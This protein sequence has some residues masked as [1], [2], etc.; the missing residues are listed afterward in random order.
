MIEAVVFDLDGVLLDSESAWA[1]VKRELTVETGGHWTD[2][3]STA[4]LGMSAPEWSR[5]MH[6][7]LLVPLEPQA[8]SE[9]VVERLAARYRAGLPIIPGARQAVERIAARWPLG[10]ASSSNPEIIELVLEQSG[11][12]DRFA[13]ALSS[14]ETGRGKPAPDVYLAAIKALG[15]QPRACVA[16]EDSGSG[17][18]AAQSAGM[19]VVAIP[20]PDFPPDDDAMSYADVVLDSIAE[21]TPAV[22]E[23]SRG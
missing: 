21:L 6:E 4:M 17:I 16:I 10:L 9:V 2:E 1:D 8:I 5:F 11:L 23:L 19:G 14:E 13:V 7:E 22:V 20:N 18:R 12:G 15:V 3:A